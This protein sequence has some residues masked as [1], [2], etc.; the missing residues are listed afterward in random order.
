MLEKFVLKKI[1]ALEKRF[2]VR[3]QMLVLEKN[4]ELEN[5]FCCKELQKNIQNDFFI[6]FVYHFFMFFLRH[7]S[8][9]YS[10][11]V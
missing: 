8:N 2:G 4:L 7:V 1:L 9:L 5:K 11:S 3:K 10:L 6:V